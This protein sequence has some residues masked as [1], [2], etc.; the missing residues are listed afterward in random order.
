MVEDDCV[1]EDEETGK[2][3]AIFNRNVFDVDLLRQ[4]GYKFGPAMRGLYNRGQAS[5]FISKELVEER[6]RD[7]I[8]WN[9]SGRF[10]KY[11]LT[12]DGKRTNMR[13][14]NMTQSIVGGLSRVGR[15]IGLSFWT[16]H[17]SAKSAILVPFFRECDKI[18]EKMDAEGMPDLQPGLDVYSK[19]F[20][21]VIANKDFRTACHRDRSNLPGSYS[22]L[23]LHEPEGRGSVEGGEVL[24][25]DYGV[26]FRMRDA[27]ALAMKSSD[28]RHCNL[29]ILGGT[30]FSFVA[31]TINYSK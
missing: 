23:V 9:S 3:I 4:T 30:R 17:R 27:D 8:D 6:F 24:L 5:G 2:T 29:P 7:R 18:T 19:R 26:A 25:P 15:K 31:Y 1:V 13:V 11:L 10:K 22:L 12:E 16:K 20:T 28:V 14:G 21:S